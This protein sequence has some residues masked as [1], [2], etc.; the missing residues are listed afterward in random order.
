[1]DDYLQIQTTITHFYLKSILY[2]GFC[3]A[4]LGVLI[5][6]IGG[7][8]LPE[9]LMQRWGWL[10]YFSAF[11]FITYGLLPYRKITRLQNKPNEIKL[12]S[13]SFL[14]F[15]SQTHFQF[16]IPL[17]LINSVRYFQKNKK[18]GMVLKLTDF[19]ENLRDNLSKFYIEMDKSKKEMIFLYFSKRSCQELDT[20]LSSDD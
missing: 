11:F 16:A 12:T 8:F 17:H 2:K 6:L 3:Y 19:P 14:E 4:F 20:A 10:I 5:L 9:P 15:W 1:M 18:Y 13:R 7:V